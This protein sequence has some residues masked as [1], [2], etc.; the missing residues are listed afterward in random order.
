MDDKKEMSNVETQR[1]FLTAEEFPEGAY[2]AAQGKDEPVENKSTPWKEGQQYYSNFAYEFRNLH[3]GTPRQY[4]G[5]HPTH[6]EEDQ[7]EE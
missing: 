6:D 1:N 7:N 2:G 3:Q 4:P 5:A